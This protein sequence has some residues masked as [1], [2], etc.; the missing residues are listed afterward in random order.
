M[1]GSVFLNLFYDSK[2][3]VNRRARSTLT[4]G[5]LVNGRATWES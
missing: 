1:A 2:V 5:A 3:D 4:L